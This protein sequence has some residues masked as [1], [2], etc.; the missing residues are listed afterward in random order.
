M[1]EFIP[2]QIGLTA[3]VALATVAVLGYLFGR[4][5]T[6]ADRQA[7]RDDLSHASN[8]INELEVISKRIR[9]TLAAQ[10]SSIQTFRQKLDSLCQIE[11]TQ[12]RQSLSAEAEKILEPT[13]NLSNDIVHAYEEIRQQTSNLSDLRSYE[14]HEVLTAN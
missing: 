12:L 11:D 8:V 5:Q 2:W 14:T 4:S 7:A 1:F 3:P 6:Q 13:V 10:H 9:S